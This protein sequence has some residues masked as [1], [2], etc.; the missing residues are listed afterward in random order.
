[1][2]IEIYYEARCPIERRTDKRCGPAHVVRTRGDVDISGETRR[3]KTVVAV[4]DH[5]PGSHPIPLEEVVACRRRGWIRCGA[6][7]AHRRVPMSS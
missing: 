6:H 2:V 4:L 1:M 5:D 3:R 7:D